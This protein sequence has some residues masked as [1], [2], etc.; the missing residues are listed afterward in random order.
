MAFLGHMTRKRPTNGLLCSIIEADAP[1]KIKVHFHYYRIASGIAEILRHA[2]EGM[3]RWFIWSSLGGT[4]KNSPRPSTVGTWLT[5][6]S[7]P[8]TVRFRK[9]PYLLSL[10]RLGMR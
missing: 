2:K 10:H 3:K 8:G 4:T 7:T 1:I 9:T 5:G 6:D